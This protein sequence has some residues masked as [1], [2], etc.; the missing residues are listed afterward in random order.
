LDS[1]HLKSVSMEVE[2]FWKA[3]TVSLNTAVI[4]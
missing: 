1:R 2:K 3:G 4:I